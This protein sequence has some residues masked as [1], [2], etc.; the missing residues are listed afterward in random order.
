MRAFAT[1]VAFLFCLTG[2]GTITNT[3]TEDGQGSGVPPRVIYGGTR[4]N[5]AVL[6]GYGDRWFHTPFAIL[7]LPFSFGLDSA[8]LPFTVIRELAFPPE[9][10]ERR[11]PRFPLG[12]P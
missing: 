5:V 4:T 12:W 8:F 1:V 11:S 7:D 10:V 3:F 2:C 9:S 6:S